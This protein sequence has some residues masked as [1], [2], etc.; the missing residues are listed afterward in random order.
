M[1]HEDRRLGSSDA[2][3]ILGLNK[4]RSPMRVFL[5][6]T[7]AIKPED[8]TDNEAVDWGN[9]LE[10]IIAEKFSKKTGIPI[11]RDQKHYV[12]EKYDFMTCTPDYGLIPNDL[13]VNEGILEI[14]NTS[15]YLRSE[16]E[17][18]VPDHAHVQ[19][20]HQLAVCNL[21]YGYICGL[22]GGNK[23]IYHRIERDDK[24][25]NTLYE[26]LGAFWQKILDKT[27]PEVRA[28][29]LDLIN[30]LYP[31]SNEKVIALP[32]NL[33]VLASEI[34]TR[35]E[36]IKVLEETNNKYEA[37]IKD[38]LKDN[39]AAE[40]DNLRISW[41]SCKT[42]RLDSTLISKEAPDVYAK[43]SKTTESRRF[44]IKEK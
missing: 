28:E 41:K 31:K 27:P 25:I 3:A 22:I 35:K 34:K 36:Q 18:G 26:I 14:K 20:Q 2:S 37:I 39:E 30:Q 6:K 23:L 12:H 44:L 1:L 17:N 43:Y 33:S 40:N 38:Y 5:E 29:D 15:E 13:G 19:L 4:Y 8:L 11:V 21:D 42:T 16:W 32:G 9:T 24:I 10:P 7:G